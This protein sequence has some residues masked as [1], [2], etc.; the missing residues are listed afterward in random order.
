MSSPGLRRARAIRSDTLFTGSAGEGTRINGISVMAVIGA[1]SSRGFRPRTTAP[2][3]SEPVLQ[4]SNVCPSGLARATSSAPIWPPAPGRFSTITGLP[5]RSDRPF[6]TKR[7]W[8]SLPP[9]AAK[10]TM[11]EIVRVG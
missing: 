3:T 1:K 4:K 10:E 11:I 7:A 5:S 8:T 9:P 2:T 6:A